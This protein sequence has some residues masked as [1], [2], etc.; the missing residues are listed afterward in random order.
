[1]N[2]HYYRLLTIAGSDS[3]GGAGI[4]ADLKTFSA[5]GCYGMSVITA[6]TAQ[7][8]QG[9]K[10]IFPVPVDIIKDQIDA[11]ITDIGIDA[12][13]IGMLYSSEVTEIIKKSIIE[14][15]LK[16]IVFDPVMVSANGDLLIEKETIQKIIYEIFPLVDIITPNVYETQVILNSDIF[17]IDDMIDSA[18]KL[19]DLNCNAVLIKGGRICKSECYDVFLSKNNDRPIIFSRKTINTKNIHGTGCTLSSAIASFLGLDFNLLDAVE[20][21]IEYTSR[22]IASSNDFILGKGKGPVNHFF[23]PVAMKF[24]YEE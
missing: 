10:S 2:K 18:R 12:L 19:I 6:I 11:V 8:T 22:A 23:N 24:K 1:M 17:S 4:Q 13:K 16:N 3:S 15:N 5:L 9:V 14:Y 7:N 20:F 21:A